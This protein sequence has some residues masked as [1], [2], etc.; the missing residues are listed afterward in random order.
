MAASIPEFRALVADGSTHMAGLVTLMLRSLGIR[1]VDEASSL[2][3][4]DE[5]LARR[6]Y[7]LVLLDDQL[8]GTAGLAMVRSLRQSP[9]HPNRLSAII[10]MAA[11]PD[12]ALIAAARDAGVTEFLRKPFSAHHIELRLEA[13]RNAPRDFVEAPAYAGPDR[14]R[15]TVGGRPRRRAADG[16]PAA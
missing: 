7:G 14:R 15:R 12:A 9:D 5:M 10:M 16:N 6:P 3:K 11:A 13:I 2:A 4:A 8:A 1:A